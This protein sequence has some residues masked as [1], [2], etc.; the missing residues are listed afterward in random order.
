[1]HS[2]QLRTKLNRFINFPIPIRIPRG[3]G[4]CHRS[5]NVSGTCV[6]FRIVKIVPQ[7]MATEIEFGFGFGF[8]WAGINIYQI[9]MGNSTKHNRSQTKPP[10]QSKLFIYFFEIFKSRC[11]AKIRGGRRCVIVVA[12][13]RLLKYDLEIW[14]WAWPPPTT[15]SSKWFQKYW[16]TSFLSNYSFSIVLVSVSDVFLG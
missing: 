15:M 13:I 10:R 12:G 7:D 4:A 9:R 16:K 6:N 14:K 2:R 5:V 3:A 8:G 11:S 1:M